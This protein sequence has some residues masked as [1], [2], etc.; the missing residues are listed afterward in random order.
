MTRKVSS[1]VAAPA[2][3]PMSRVTLRVTRSDS[4]TGAAKT[5]MSQRTVA[6]A[7]VSRAMVL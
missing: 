7:N 5:K 3:I 6:A 2:R 1:S 4:P